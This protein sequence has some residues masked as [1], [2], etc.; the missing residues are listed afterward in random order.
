MSNLKKEQILRTGQDLFRR[1]GIRRVTVGDICQEAGVSKMT[2]YKHFSNKVD[3]AVR[4]FGQLYDDYYVYFE[5][6]FSSDISFE[7]KLSGL[8]KTK[9]DAAENMSLEV[10]HDLYRS[11]FPALKD[12]FEQQQKRFLTMTLNFIR[13]G[14]KEGYIRKNLSNEFILLQI[15]QMAEMIRNDDL[16]ALYD[17]T[18]TLTRDMLDY[19]FYGILS[20]KKKR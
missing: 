6:L 13:Q 16:L 18:Q 10:V 14:K 1:F 2:F 9:L 5:H 12:V 3:L 17:N 19:F 11:E 7:E 8:I 20:G 15:N 4:I